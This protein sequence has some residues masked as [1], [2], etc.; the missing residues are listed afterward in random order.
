MQGSVN[1]K[2]KKHKM[3]HHLHPVLIIGGL[4]RYLVHC[5]THSLRR[6]TRA[7]HAYIDSPGDASSL[8][9]FLFSN[10]TLPS[11][12]LVGYLCVLPSDSTTN[13]ILLPTRSSLSEGPAVDMYQQPPPEN[14]YDNRMSIVSGPKVKKY[15]TPIWEDEEDTCSRS[16][17]M[18][19][20]SFK[21]KEA[22][23][24]KCGTRERAIAMPGN[25]KNYKL[26]QSPSINGS[27]TSFNTQLLSSTSGSSFSSSLTS[28]S[29][30]DGYPHFS[31]S[32]KTS[33][34]GTPS[35]RSG[36]SFDTTRER[37]VSSTST[38]KQ[39]PKLLD[40]FDETQKTPSSVAAYFQGIPEGYSGER[41]ARATPSSSSRHIKR[42]PMP[43][44]A[45]PLA[46]STPSFGLISLAEAQDRE[47]IRNG[48]S[49]SAN[50]M[51]TVPFPR[52]EDFDL[53][54]FSAR[55]QTTPRTRTPG[56]HH[57]KNKKSGIMRLI[58]RTPRSPP[59]FLI[60]S[61]VWIELPNASEPIVA[62]TK[63]NNVLHSKG[64]GQ[65]HAHALAQVQVQATSVAPYRPEK[66]IKR[67]M[68]QL[69]LRPVSMNFAN[70]LPLQYLTGLDDDIPDVP[71]TPS[72][73]LPTTMLH[74][75]TPLM[76]RTTGQIEYDTDQSKAE[77]IQELEAQVK[78]LQSLLQTAES[79]QSKTKMTTELD[80]CQYCGKATVGTPSRQ[81]GIMD[82]GRVK[83]GVGRAVFGSGSLHERE[84]L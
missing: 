65:A 61:P 62:S 83:T 70:G 40:A 45:F 32:T 58:S 53:P 74:L 52:P 1:G 60:S 54:L 30:S 5:L 46:T 43:E 64:Q 28:E 8:L 29:S 73:Y 75:K 33:H 79:R 56:S 20:L 12:L 51:G 38:L 16:S 41:S 84:L 76:E 13:L 34:S 66:S 50:N 63:L 57:I 17:T 19:D 37:E 71:P 14:I 59:P 18:T 21:L 11:P 69:E 7:S 81:K 42:H 35:L 44:E 77:R 3:S 27:T 25:W 22:V 82:R 68:P 80:R 4:A 26:G 49:H 9:T 24:I 47:R 72:A 31:S 39:T 55:T 48:N 78:E 15:E 10:C 6:S 23:K 67:L 2:I 36:K